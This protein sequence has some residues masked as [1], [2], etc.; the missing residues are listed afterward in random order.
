M[1]TDELVDLTPQQ[2]LARSRYAISRH[3]ARGRADDDGD[4]EESVEALEAAHSSRWGKLKYMARSWWRHHPA[5]YAYQAVRP[6]LKAYARDEPL[7]LLGIATAVGA[8]SM[9]I[10][11]WRM[12][13]LTAL[14]LAPLKSSRFTAAAVALLASHSSDGASPDSP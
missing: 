13:P 9:V 3:L 10:R 12:L 7:K 1:D 4:D 5:N 8:A 2:R 14:A 6:A 11:P